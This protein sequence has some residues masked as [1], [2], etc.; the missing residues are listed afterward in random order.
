MSDSQQPIHQSLDEIRAQ[1]DD[2]SGVSPE[3]R[4]HLRDVLQEL[5]HALKAAAEEEAESPSAEQQEGIVDRL[6][7]SARHFE[8]EHPAMSGLVGSLIDALGNMGI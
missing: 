2:L 6:K 7:E 5:E 4:A 1:L 8:E 3:Q